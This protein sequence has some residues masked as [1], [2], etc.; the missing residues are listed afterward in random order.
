MIFRPEELVI[1]GHSGMLAGDCLGACGSCGKG[2]DDGH[3]AASQFAFRRSFFRCTPSSEA[4]LSLS[5]PLF[6]TSW[7]RHLR[8]PLGSV[9]PGPAHPFEL[10]A[11][12]GWL[13]AGEAG[14]GA[15]TWSSSGL[16]W[17]AAADGQMLRGRS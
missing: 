3:S 16:A 17:L 4:R 1:H 14:G 12:F 11:V 6:V 2:A 5:I 13:L 9:R 7:G 8:R 10:S 15:G